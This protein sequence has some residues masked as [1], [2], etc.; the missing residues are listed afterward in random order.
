MIKYT[1]TLKINMP[2]E[3][4]RQDFFLSIQEM[5]EKGTILFASDFGDIKF[6]SINELK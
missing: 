2:T 6:K 3:K 1:N 5:L 4:E